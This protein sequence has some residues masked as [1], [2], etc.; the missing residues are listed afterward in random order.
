MQVT[1]RAR[2]RQADIDRVVKAAVR[3]GLHVSGV[4]CHPD[5][6]IEVVTL[7]NVKDETANSAAGFQDR[8]RKAAGWG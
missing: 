6:Q 8:L 2:V 7:D 1:R 5:G 4:K 3:A